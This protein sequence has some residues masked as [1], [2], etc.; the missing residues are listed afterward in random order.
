MT[1]TKK[2]K[3]KLKWERERAIE[4]KGTM[5]QHWRASRRRSIDGIETSGKI[6]SAFGHS[7]ARQLVRRLS[8]AIRADENA[9]RIHRLS[10]GN[11]SGMKEKNMTTV[12]F[13]H[14]LT[15]KND[16]QVFDIR[17]H[18]L[19]RTHTDEEKASE[20]ERERAH[21]SSTTLTSM[22]WL[23]VEPNGSFNAKV[24][25]ERIA[26]R[27]RKKISNI[28]IIYLAPASEARK[29]IRLLLVRFALPISSSLAVFFLP[30]FIAYR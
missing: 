12:L 1:K 11:L 18:T 30:S 23:P 4:T 5:T 24:G 3:K 13:F 22:S 21:V 10:V 26:G 20:R 15:L 14:A 25:G 16:V 2:K 7:A 19:V 17:I 27:R 29:E 6:L 8:W 9:G 28:A